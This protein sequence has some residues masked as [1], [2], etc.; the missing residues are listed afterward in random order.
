[1]P[2]AKRKFGGLRDDAEAS[3]KKTS[4]AAAAASISASCPPELPG[5]AWGNVLNF[6]PYH[7]VRTAL[8]VCRSIAFDAPNFVTHIQVHNA[9]ELNVPAARRFPNATHLAFQCVVSTTDV[10]LNA[11]AIGRVVPF[12]TAFPNLRYCSLTG[13]YGIPYASALC[14]GPKNHN[15]LYRNMLDAL[16]GAFETEAVSRSLFLHGFLP[17][18]TTYSCT[19]PRE[20]TSRNCN[21]CRR[22]VQS[23]PLSAIIIVPGS[24]RNTKPERSQQ[25][26]IPQDDYLLMIRKRAWTRECFKYPTRLPFNFFSRNIGSPI[27]DEEGRRYDKV[28]Y[29][30][31]SRLKQFQ[32][33]EELGYKLNRWNSARMRKLLGLTSTDGKVALLESTFNHLFQLGFHI[34]RED[35]VL[36]PASA[37]PELQSLSTLYA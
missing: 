37:R 22:I 6:L 18:Y 19:P 3:R 35:F 34:P 23:Y 28:Y 29:M 33:M 24:R 27:V 1:M 12:M 21:L 16:C 20:D 30:N 13:K 32:L 15:A 5:A 26:C 8:L 11:D 4:A 17:F 31:D 25:F 14:Q 10:S 7:H 2:P 9:S 36:V